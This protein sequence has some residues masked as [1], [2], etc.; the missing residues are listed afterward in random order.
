MRLS[1]T[2]EFPLRDGMNAVNLRTVWKAD[3]AYPE[4]IQK[5]LECEPWV[6]G[7]KEELEERLPVPETHG[8]FTELSYYRP[9]GSYRSFYYYH[10]VEDS[11]TRCPVFGLK[12]LEPCVPGADMLIRD[13]LRPCYSPH[14]IVE[15]LILEE[16]KVPGALCLKDAMKE[17]VCA[18]DIQIAHLRTYGELARLPIPLF[19]FRHE[20]S[21]E[22]QFFS[23][24]RDYVS[25]AAWERLEPLLAN[26]LG[27]YV[28][29]YPTPPIRVRDVEF[30]LQGL[31]FRKRMFALL[32]ICDPDELISRWVANFA[33]ILHLGFL[34]GSL[35]SY[36]TGICCQPQN[37]CMDGGFVD[38]DSLTLLHSLPDDTAI[39][40]GLE[41]S[42]EALISTVRA[43]ITG[44]TDPTRSEDSGG[45]FDLHHLRLFVI[46]GIQRALKLEARPH[47]ITLHPCIED[48]FRPAESV[49]TLT[50]RLASYF[51][52]RDGSF[53]R[54]AREFHSIGLKLL[55]FA[56]RG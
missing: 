26:G 2:T 35:S 24:I 44:T 39:A 50:E 56:R 23:I 55:A 6:K 29:Y 21:V 28:Y 5:L 19:V 46:N 14:T 38:L 16:A 17:A 4:L 7:V 25:T 12:G 45:R 43:L 33:R 32:G 49:S 52:E 27:A 1:H 11:E 51:S 54:S 30:L 41:F 3:H 42:T 13:L 8:S 31:D 48:Y 20:R 9:P 36:R 40:A 18:G 37:S 34:P 47:T 53:E 10:S 22:E 15:H